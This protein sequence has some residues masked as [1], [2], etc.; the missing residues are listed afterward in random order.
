MYGQ[1]IVGKMYTGTEANQIYGPVA[2]SVSIP[3]STLGDLLKL[4]G[5][6]IMFRIE[7]GNLTILDSQRTVI[8]PGNVTIKDTDVFRFFSVSLVS[9]LISDG[10]SASTS[11][12][13][14]NNNILTI[15]NGT[16]TLEY[17][18]LCPPFCP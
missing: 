12:E 2:V 13:I 9:K 14:R 3:T 4:N 10:G 7:N 15:T 1:N 17:S 16:Y 8:Y 5:A 6:Y 11:V 18:I